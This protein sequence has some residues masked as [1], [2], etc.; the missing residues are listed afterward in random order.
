MI[1]ERASCALLNRLHSS[2]QTETGKILALQTKAQLGS[3]IAR[4]PFNDGE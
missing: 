3:S 2:I 1:S 4:L